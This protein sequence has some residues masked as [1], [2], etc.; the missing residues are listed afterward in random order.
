VLVSSTA[1]V[2]DLSLRYHPWLHKTNVLTISFPTSTVD[3]VGLVVKIRH[4]SDVSGHIADHVYGALGQEQYHSEEVPTRTPSPNKTFEPL[5][6][7]HH[8][9][10]ES[11]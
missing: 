5:D 7:W 8:D 11:N 10:S 3:N 2:E 6:V 9:L 1:L 4:Y